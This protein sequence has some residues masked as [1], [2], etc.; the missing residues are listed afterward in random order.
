MR[1]NYFPHLLLGS[2]IRY[3][4]DQRIRES[5]DDAESFSE[6]FK[7]IFHHERTVAHRAMRAVMLVIKTHPEF[8]Q[9]HHEQILTLLTNADRRELKSSVIQLI[10]LLSLHQHEVERV[11]HILAYLALNQNEQRTIR[12]NALQSLYDISNTHAGFT[13]QFHHALGA[14]SN[15]PTPSV[16][17][18]VLKL[19][20]Q[21]EKINKILV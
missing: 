21:T 19:R 15:D 7:L 2:R 17:A 12:V 9:A 3:D 4:R 8:L 11:W 1:E 16:Q 13:D 10:P 14:L 20:E 6:L 5:V 18:K